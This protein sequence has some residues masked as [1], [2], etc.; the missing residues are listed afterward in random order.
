MKKIIPYLTPVAV[1]LIAGCAAMPSGSE[2]D[3]LTADIVRASFRDEG[4]V[5][6]DRLVQDET[7]RE[8]SAADVAGR[9]AGCLNHGGLVAADVF[10]RI[11]VIVADEHTKTVGEV[12]IHQ[13]IVT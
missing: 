7:N 6:V 4:L 10:V 12:V 8:C 13:A 11:E 2:L 5:K 1:L 9:A 3:K